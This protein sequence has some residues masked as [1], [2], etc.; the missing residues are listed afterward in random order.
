MKLLADQYKGEVQFAYIDAMKYRNLE[1]A[2]GVK[3]LPTSLFYKD[4]MWYE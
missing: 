3:L 4:G 2:F 1:L